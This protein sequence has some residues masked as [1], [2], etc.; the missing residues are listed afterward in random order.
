MAESRLLCLPPELLQMV[1]SH[2]DDTASISRLCRSCSGLYLIYWKYLYR[3]D[4]L[5]ASGR[6]CKAL[7]ATVAEST[8]DDGIRVLL[9]LNSLEADADPN[10]CVDQITWLP[11]QKFL[12]SGK[13]ECV[14]IVKAAD[15]R[16]CSLLVKVLK[17]FGADINRRTEGDGILY[18]F[19]KPTIDLSRFEMKYV[20]FASV[21][22]MD[23]ILADYGSTTLRP[24]VDLAAGIVVI[25]KHN[26][27]MVSFLFSCEKVNVKR[28]LK[29]REQVDG[30]AGNVQTVRD[31]VF[32]A[33]CEQGDMGLASLVVRLAEDDDKKHARNWIEK[34]ELHNRHGLATSIREKWSDV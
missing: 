12:R 26:W 31:Y 7:R 25:D 13:L 16:K 11:S 28:S 9:A 21:L 27:A 1:V 4:A 2:L 29:S 34:A 19:R 20:E 15:E 33:A 23:V 6:R 14:S 24:L 17:Y 22:D 5:L 8:L 30:M 32:R 10:S 18:Q 3:Y